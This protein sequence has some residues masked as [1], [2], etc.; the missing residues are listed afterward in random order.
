MDV[1]YRLVEDC[2]LYFDSCF[3]YGNLV[4]G[5]KISIDKNCLCKIFFLILNKYLIS[6]LFLFQLIVLYMYVCVFVKCFFYDVFKF[7]KFKFMIN[8]W[9]RI[10]L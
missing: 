10:L 6:N 8:F 9:V 2:Y 4:G 7:D 1:R 3:L 5:I